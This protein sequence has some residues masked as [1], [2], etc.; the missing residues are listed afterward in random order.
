M[1]NK[2]NEV[3][4]NLRAGYINGSAGG[5]LVSSNIVP[6]TFGF[7]QGWKP[8]MFGTDK[9]DGSLISVV[10]SLFHLRLAPATRKIS[11]DLP[12]N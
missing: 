1:S 3:R 6:Q 12:L 4:K 11:S 8:Q 7:L 9:L 10:F 5:A 2:A